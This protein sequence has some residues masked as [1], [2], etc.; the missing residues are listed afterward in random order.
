MQGRTRAFVKIQDG[1]NRRCAYCIIPSARG[2]S[3]SREA[4]SILAELAALA[5]AGYAEVVF[6]GINLP[7]Y[8]LDTGTD[9]AALIKA[10]EAVPNLRR[11]RLSSLE[12][13]SITP[14]QT[15]R[16]AASPLLCR[17][18]HL[19]LQSGCTATLRRMARPYTAPVYAETVRALRAAL[20]GASFTTDVIAG[21][22]GEG[23][24]EFEESLAFITQMRF[25][26]VHV[27]PF[28][29]R[30]GTPAAGMPGQLPRHEK[31]RR[32]GVL[33]AAAEAVRAEWIAEQ[34]GTRHEVLLETPLDNGLFSGYTQN[35]IPVQVA[36]P[37]SVRGDILPVRL[38]SFKGERCDAQPL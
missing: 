33:R 17:H 11:V 16:F 24:D 18:F 19:S 26:K 7:S 30:P 38:G 29:A 15:E 36:A 5:A 12:P 2:P 32:A 31:A 3:R 37:G 22:P 20:P 27:F 23:E 1:C 10:A 9:I 13:D 35:Y 28:S 25:L 14:A 21:F 8:G 4:Q 6:T 34:R